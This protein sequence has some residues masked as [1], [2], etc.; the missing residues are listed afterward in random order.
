MTDRTLTLIVC[1]APLAARAPEVVAALAAAGW[2]LSVVATPAAADWVDYEGVA[3]V[4]GAPATTDHRSPGEPKRGP[5]PDVV[6]VD[7]ATFNTLNKLAAGI[8]DI[9]ALGVLNETLA[10]GTPIVAV[11]AVNERLWRHPAWPST[12]A[13]LTEAGVTLL[14]VR[15]GDPSP[16]PVC[17]GT[18]ADLAAAFDPAWLVS[19]V[20]RLPGS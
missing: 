7:P 1:A 15:T 8:S 3:K 9:C 6:V 10:G 18:G 11:P 16:R 4:T 20:A 14:D 19:A 17:P 5:R 13:R 2:T 12:L